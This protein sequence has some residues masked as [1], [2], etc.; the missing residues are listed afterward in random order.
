MK[1]KICGITTKSALETAILHG[2]DFV[3]FV[4]FDKSKRNISIEN[5]K[6]LAK[7]IPE[8]IKKVGVFVD[9][10]IENLKKIAKE[11]PLDIVQLHGNE[12]H[13]YLENC[14]GEVCP[15]NFEVIKVIRVEDGEFLQN[16]DDFPDVLLM[17]DA[18][19]SGGGEKFDWQKIDFDKLKGRKF[20]V[21]GGLNPE[22]VRDA[23]EYF[24]PFAVD[25]SS[26][27]ETNEQKDNEKICDF[28]KQTKKLQH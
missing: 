21:A 28:L 17:L 22:N 6:E 12:S 23:I 4:F 10:P 13:E 27:V 25:V 2:A 15:L 8:N 20:F 16:P 3:G 7:I 14:R 1:T 5:A 24:K 18:K 9:E 11:I 19:T 26:G